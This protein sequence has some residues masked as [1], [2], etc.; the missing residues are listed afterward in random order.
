MSGVFRAISKL[1]GSGNTSPAARAVAGHEHSVANASTQQHHGANARPEPQPERVQSLLC[2]GTTFT[3]D[4]DA[5]GG[6]KIA[7]EVTGS[8]RCLDGALVLTG[9]IAGDAYADL[10]FVDGT[11]KGNLHC[12][13]VVLGPSAVIEGAIYYGSMQMQ[14]GATISGDMH[15]TDGAQAARI[16]PTA[17]PKSPATQQTS[18]KLSAVATA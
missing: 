15:R 13:R 14:E 1:L 9:R 7:G 5:A 11:V 16:V 18:A 10:A 6:I 4:L 12:G 17:P 3:G 8:V 2:E